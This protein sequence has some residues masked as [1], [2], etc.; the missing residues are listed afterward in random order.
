[1]GQSTGIKRYDEQQGRFPNPS[2]DFVHRRTEA[3]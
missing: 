2:L 3:I 1:M